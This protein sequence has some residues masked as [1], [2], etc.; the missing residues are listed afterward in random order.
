MRRFLWVVVVF[1]CAVPAI[2]GPL[3]PCIRAASSASG[4]FLVIT[5][6]EFSHLL[7][8]SAERV[9]L[10]VVPRETIDR[11]TIHKI[12]SPNK[13][14]IFG[15]W[16]GWSVQIEKRDRLMSPCPISIISDDGEYLVLLMEGPRWDWA[17]RIYRRA[18]QGYKGIIVKD[19]TLE[20]IWPKNKSQEWH[21]ATWTDESPEWFAGGSFAFSADSHT[22]IHKTRWG[23]TVRIGLAD[24]SVSPQ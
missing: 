20:D 14:W 2:A 10:S 3:A 12:A 15:G 1:L 22:L 24:G 11:D 4:S 21:N 19:I 18:E 9:T 6:V 13:Y 17:I 23:D 16:N 8:A 5:D 7:P